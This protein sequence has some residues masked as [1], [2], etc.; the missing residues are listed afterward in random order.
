MVA[1]LENPAASARRAHSS[2]CGPVVPRTLFGMPMPMSIALASRQVVL[3]HPLHR[4][5]VTT[6]SGPEGAPRGTGGTARPARGFRGGP[7]EVPRPARRRSAS[8]CTTPSWRTGAAGAAG[9]QPPTVTWLNGRWGSAHGKTTNSSSATTASTSSPASSALPRVPPGRVRQI[10]P[11]TS[12]L[13]SFA[14]GRWP[15]RPLGLRD[16]RAVESGVHDQPLPRRETRVTGGQRQIG[17]AG[18]RVGGRAGRRG[19]DL[20][21]G[22]ADDLLARD[23]AGVGGE[24]TAGP[25][26]EHAVDEPAVGRLDDDRI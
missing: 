14:E 2:N 19:D 23:A 12:A 26:A 13:S 8:V 4:C 5:T 21:R 7:R 3:A 22:R 9:A 20:E 10:Q 18:R 1:R 24:V 11:Y 17:P 16:P 25:V 6:R 15:V